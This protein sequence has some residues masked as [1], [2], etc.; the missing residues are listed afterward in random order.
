L[1]LVLFTIGIVFTNLVMI[2]YERNDDLIM[3][4]K[5][6][7]MPVLANLSSLLN[8]LLIAMLSPYSWLR[9][10][11]WLVVGLIV[12]F[13]YGVKNSV[14]NPL[15]PRIATSVPLDELTAFEQEKMN[16]DDDADEVSDTELLLQ[17]TNGVHYSST[18]V[19]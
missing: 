15:S 6:P 17:N 13:V 2:A 14:E 1:L 9:F 7:L 18:S 10:A 11:A 16:C 19:Q 12:Y 8:I 4:F 3:T 5:V